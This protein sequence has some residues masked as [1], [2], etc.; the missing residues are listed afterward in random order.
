MNS[1]HSIGSDNSNIQTLL[2]SWIYSYRICFLS[3]E[4]RNFIPD[5]LS[6]NQIIWK[7]LGK[8]EHKSSISTADINNWWSF[9]VL[10]MLLV[11]YWKFPSV[12]NNFVVIVISNSIKW[13]IMKVPLCKIWIFWNCYFYFIHWVYM[14]SHSVFALFWHIHSSYHLTVCVLY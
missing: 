9:F 13:W 14:S 6:K 1:F 4:I 5:F 12:N 10:I 8:S 11:I 3:D 2:I 7:V